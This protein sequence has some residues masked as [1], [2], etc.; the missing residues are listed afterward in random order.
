MSRLRQVCQ[1]RA[2]A[3]AERNEQVIAQPGR[4]RDVPAPPELGDVGGQVRHVEILGQLVAE[5]VGRA[6]R[7]VGV[8]GEVA[9]DLH[10]V[11]EHAHPD[12]R[13]AIQ[14]RVGEDRVGEQGHV[15]GDGQLLEQAHQEELHA[16]VDAGPVPVL[17]AANLRQEVLGADDRPGHE[18]REE[19]DEEQEVAEVA[20][21]R[22]LRR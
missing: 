5:Q 19:Q 15:V 1:P 4:Q 10:R 22:I 16:E 8:A 2:A 11:G 20:L 12:G 3:A 18:V 17:A 6:D 9:V 7:H 14:R 13:G 21:G